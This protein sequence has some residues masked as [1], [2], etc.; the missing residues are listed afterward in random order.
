[1]TSPPEDNSLRPVFGE[2]DFYNYSRYY[3]SVPLTEL[4]GV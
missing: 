3:L 4:G 2:I 1:L